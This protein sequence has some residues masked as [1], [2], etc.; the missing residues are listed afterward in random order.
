MFN[1]F[2][3]SKKNIV[4]TSVLAVLL[5]ALVVCS[6]VVRAEEGNCPDCGGVGLLCETC[7]G[8]GTM[9]SRYFGT[10]M[11]LA[12]PIIAI[13]LALIF[14]VYWLI[15]KKTKKFG[16]ITFGMIAAALLLSFLGIA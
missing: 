11:S 1:Q 4:M 15:S 16:L 6:F 12:A 13:V 8:D 3:K 7:G 5:I 9:D 2:F 10:F 14:F